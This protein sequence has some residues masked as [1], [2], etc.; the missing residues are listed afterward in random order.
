MKRSRFVIILFALALVS[1]KENFQVWKDSNESFLKETVDSYSLKL[2]NTGLYKNEIFRGYGA[3]P[4]R[5]SFV[6]I[7]YE[8]TMVDG[9]SFTS[10]DTMGYLINYPIGIQNALLQ[11]NR[12]SIWQICLP[13]ELGYG[14]S[15]T[16]DIYGNYEIPPFTTLF[17]KE[18]ELI[19]VVQE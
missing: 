16:K 4:N 8:A 19:E 3:R 18:L 7:R 15:G 9:R 13:F 14:N 12:E 17:F 11:M 5:K 6:Q 10:I 2:D 1:C